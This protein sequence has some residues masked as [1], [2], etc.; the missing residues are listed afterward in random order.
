[1]ILLIGA[2]LSPSI[3]SQTNKI[4]IRTINGSAGRGWSDNFDSYTDGQFLDGDPTDG[5]W[6]GWDNDPA[7]GAFVTSAQAFSSPHSV[8][9]N[10][11]SNLVHEYSGY[12]AGQWTYTAW[13]YIPEDFIGETAFILLCNYSP[14]GPYTWSTQLRFNTDTMVVLSDFD[15][16]E[17]P[18][19][20]DQWIEIRV[21]IDLD[22]DIQ[23]IYYDGDLLVEKSWKEGVTGGGIAN[24][25][26]ID[27]FAN[28]AT[29]VYYDDISLEGEALIPDLC[30]QG[31]LRWEGIGA[32]AIVTGSFEVSNCGDAGSS[33]D[34]QV[35]TWPTWGTWTFTPSSGTG[36][37]PAQG[38]QTIQV[39]CDAP[40]QTNQEFTG[41][42][43]VVNTNNAADYCEID[44]YLSTPRARIISYT[45]ITTILERF[46][47]AF[48]VLRQ[49]FS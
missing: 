25:A 23:Q 11:D 16:A 13:Q 35:D 49:I 44:V 26:A 20:Y 36:L 17:L 33:L 29:S 5:E 45:L 46:P 24:I 15:G 7:F 47:N 28:A 12:T 30:C 6:A 41:T 22:A 8:D 39:Q 32:G 34:W 9:I 48:P 21:E 2:A 14:G 18:L 1:M 40:A 42:I 10:G 43:K 19:I 38:W 4:N 37:T 3:S 27:L 31:D